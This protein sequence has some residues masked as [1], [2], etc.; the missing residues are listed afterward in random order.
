MKNIVV[1]GVSTGIGRGIAAVL[2]RQGWRVFGSVRKEA[3]AT[4]LQA[5]LG[6]SFV[7]LVFDVEDDGAIVAASVAVR[8]HLGGRT[9]DGLV[10]ND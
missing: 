2:A 4:A 7:P 6:D 1:T 10:N 9:L 8:G 3:D 5:L